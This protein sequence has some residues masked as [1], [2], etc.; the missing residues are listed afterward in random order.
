VSFQES[1]DVYISKSS[2]FE[3]SGVANLGFLKA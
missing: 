3:W 1:M 2:S